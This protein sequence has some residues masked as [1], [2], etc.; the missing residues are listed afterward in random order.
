LNSPEGLKGQSAGIAEAQ[1]NG[2]NFSIS[3]LKSTVWD[4]ELIPEKIRRMKICTNKI[5]FISKQINLFFI[6]VA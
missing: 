3:G 2:S 5:L 1:T 4:F 6:T